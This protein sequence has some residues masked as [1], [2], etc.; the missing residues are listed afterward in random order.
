ML[1]R[2]RDPFDEAPPGIFTP[3]NRCA[4]P[5]RKPRA[6]RLNPIKHKSMSEVIPSADIL[7]PLRTRTMQITL[8]INPS[9][10]LLHLTSFG[11]VRAE[12]QIIGTMTIGLHHRQP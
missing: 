2:R 10:E 7:R 12:K 5:W 11:T 4:N 1:L 9:F 6:R 8:S 3:I